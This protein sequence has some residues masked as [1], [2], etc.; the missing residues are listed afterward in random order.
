MKDLILPK[1]TY[2]IIISTLLT[3]IVRGDWPSFQHDAAHTGR[4]HT[5]FDVH[6]LE[7]H[8]TLHGA[9]YPPAIY[10]D[11]LLLN[12][13][14]AISSYRLQD[15]ELLW[16]IV[17]GPRSTPISIYGDNMVYIAE[18]KSTSPTLYVHNVHSGQLK[19]SFPLTGHPFVGLSPTLFHDPTTDSLIAYV[20]ATNTYSAITIGDT[21][22]SLLW[23]VQVPYSGGFA[24]STVVEDSLIVDS[25]GQYLAI[26]RFTGEFYYFHQGGVSGGGGNTVAYDAKLGQ[27][28]VSN[29]YDIGDSGL[30]YDAVSAYKYNSHDNIELVWQFNARADAVAIGHNGSVY[31]GS[32]DMWELDPNT[33][34]ALRVFEVE[35][36]SPFYGYLA[37]GMIP[38]VT[39]RYVWGYS[40]IYTIAFDLQ[41]GAEARALPGSIGPYNTP[42]GTSVILNDRYAVVRTSSALIIYGIPVPEPTAHV[43]S[44]ALVPALTILCR[45]RSPKGL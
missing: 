36:G 1:A 35:S 38:V 12:N 9:Y 3:G 42:Y 5:S 11:S 10:G 28:Y 17:P 44:S 22:A 7:E 34:E 25:P 41:T 14:E 24:H 2:A 37:Y 16:S 23:E 43:L 40:P 6:S 15:G 18:S 19:Y 27:F 26:D 21:S 4:S 8:W 33:G 13:N 45:H 39:D 30:S 32:G 31:V 29:T 20:S